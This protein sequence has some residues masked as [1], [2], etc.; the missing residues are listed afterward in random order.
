MCVRE[1]EKSER[2][3]RGIVAGCYRVA[4]GG[5][6]PVLSVGIAVVVRPDFV[7]NRF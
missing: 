7:Q 2:A 4:V 3:L 6:V 1:R 5:R